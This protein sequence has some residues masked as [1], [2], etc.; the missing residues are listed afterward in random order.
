MREGEY[1]MS[2]RDATASLEIA[3]LYDLKLFKARGLLIL[4]KIY[5]R[6]RDV[7]GAREL[8]KMGSEIANACDYFTC[9]RGFKELELLLDAT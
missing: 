1:E 7:D 6:R 3:A 5:H 4:A 2:V 9:V 8:V